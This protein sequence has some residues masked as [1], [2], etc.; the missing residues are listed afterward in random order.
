M[1]KQGFIAILHFEMPAAAEFR[2]N[3]LKAAAIVERWGDFGA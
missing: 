2:R 1:M 3:F